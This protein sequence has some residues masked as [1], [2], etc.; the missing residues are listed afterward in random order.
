MPINSN[1]W[2]K[3]RTHDSTYNRVSTFL[4]SNK[5]QAFTID[6]IIEKIDPLILDTT[7]YWTILENYVKISSVNIALQKL[8]NE[9]IVQAK[10]IEKERIVTIQYKAV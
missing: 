4:Q 2:E 8:L 10:R 5:N 7:E 3:G 6:E 9:G 1:E